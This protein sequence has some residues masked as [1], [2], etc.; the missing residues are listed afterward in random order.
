MKYF[1]SNRKYIVCSNN[2]EWCKTQDIFA[3]PNITINDITSENKGYFDLCIISNC[4]DFIVCNS[5]FSW[6]GAWL[7]NDIDKTIIAPVHWY[8]P[9]LSH[10]STKDLI[11]E[12][13]ILVD[14]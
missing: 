7:G 12:K 4:R 8:G 14:K 13:W 1:G 5:S 6:W 10:I 2:V 11:P 3:K 9:G